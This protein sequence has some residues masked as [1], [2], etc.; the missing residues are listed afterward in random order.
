[1]P[2]SVRIFTA[3]L[4]GKKFL[5]SQQVFSNW[6]EKREQKRRLEN[7]LHAQRV[8]FKVQG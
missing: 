7:Y 6:E 4:G 1:M 3:T 8:W 2:F 5:T